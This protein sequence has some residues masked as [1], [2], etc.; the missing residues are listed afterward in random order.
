[1][2]YAAQMY[3]GIGGYILFY[4]RPYALA[5]ST[6]TGAVTALN[7]PTCGCD[8]AL[9][10]DGL[11]FAYLNYVDGRQ[12]LVL[13]DLATGV[14]RVIPGTPGFGQCG[15]LR[16]TPDSARLVYAEA[17]GDPGAGPERYNLRLVSLASS[18]VTPLLA[19]VE[20]PSL[21]VVGWLEGDVV[22]VTES[23]SERVNAAGRTHFSPYRYIGMLP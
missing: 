4:W 8:A 6:A 5:I 3:A 12:D 7:A 14:E 22:I 2:V 18:E 21:N 13:R 19:A 10:P 9:S 17:R 23:G 15:D 16:F 11:I 20:E 1:M